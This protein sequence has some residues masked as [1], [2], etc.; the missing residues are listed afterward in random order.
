MLL[1]SL[2]RDSFLKKIQACL[3]HFLQLVRGGERWEFEE[4]IGGLGNWSNHSS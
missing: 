1:E 4:L 2:I 3:K